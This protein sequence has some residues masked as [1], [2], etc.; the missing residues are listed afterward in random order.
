MYK[1]NLK[2]NDFKKAYNFSPK[3]KLPYAYKNLYYYSDGKVHQYKIINDN[4]LISF[5]YEGR[6]FYNSSKSKE[7]NFTATGVDPIKTL[8]IFKINDSQLTRLE[9][10][11][12]NNKFDKTVRLKKA[13]EIVPNKKI[14][15]CV[16]G[17]CNNET[18]QT[19][20]SKNKIGIPFTGFVDGFAF[21]TEGLINEKGEIVIPRKIELNKYSEEELLNITETIIENAHKHQLLDYKISGLNGKNTYWV[22][23]YTIWSHRGTTIST[24]IKYSNPIFS[25][26]IYDKLN[27]SM[28]K[29]EY[30]EFLAK[31][32]MPDITFWVFSKSDSYNW[33]SKNSS[34]FYG[35]LNI[36]FMINNYE[37]IKELKEFMDKRPEY[38]DNLQ[39]EDIY[40]GKFPFLMFQFVNSEN[41]ISN[42]YEGESKV[43]KGGNKLIAI[44]DVINKHSINYK[45]FSGNSYQLARSDRPSTKKFVVPSKINISNRQFNQTINYKYKESGAYKLNP[46]S[47]EIISGKEYVYVSGYNDGN[48]A[49]ISIT[50][51]GNEMTGSNVCSDN[52][53][54]EYK[55]ENGYSTKE[56][57]P[58]MD[59]GSF[60]M[61]PSYVTINYQPSCGKT[62]RFIKIKINSPGQY[63]INIK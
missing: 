13:Y 30:L 58:F 25:Y 27:S 16:D 37:H 33:N 35:N 5:N 1:V 7:L 26:N 55:Q 44:K 17:Y 24:S 43:F 47:Y 15:M 18:M 2:T 61:F 36:N 53:F 45:A 31:N 14:V 56:D 22:K 46:S 6:F 21:T 12:A 34:I 9:N 28:K 29:G 39:N 60:D 4:L 41:D 42:F 19:V 57:S 50:D 49:Y 63:D 10:D 20:F 38:Q 59:S 32:V 8:K 40:Y 11:L 62:T 3:E 23:P 54:V 48:K 51:G 52:Y